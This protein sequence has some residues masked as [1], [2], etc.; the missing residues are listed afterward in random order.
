MYASSRPH[1][2]LTSHLY[3][4][5]P[6][7]YRYPSNRFAFSAHAG[8]ACFLAVLWGALWNYGKAAMVAYAVYWGSCKLTCRGPTTRVE[9]P[10][11]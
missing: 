7:T 3:L 6:T 11:P 8:V 4:L 9:T 10:G 2:L 5:H 1:V